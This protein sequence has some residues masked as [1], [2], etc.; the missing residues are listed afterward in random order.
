[1]TLTLYRL[2]LVMTGFVVE[3]FYYTKSILIQTRRV[4]SH[5]KLNKFNYLYLLALSLTSSRINQ[6]VYSSYSVYVFTELLQKT[7]KFYASLVPNNLG[8]VSSN[9]HKS[10]LLN[11][12]KNS[13][14]FQLI[15]RPRYLANF[16]A[17]H[18]HTVKD[19][20]KKFIIF[21]LNMFG[22]AYLPYNIS[23][24]TYNTYVWLSWYLKLNPMNNIF[25][26]KV[27]NY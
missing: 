14:T 5:V 3:N 27:Y 10:V 25:Y 23:F 19:A 9:Y 18:F 16:E 7:W 26:L 11:L 4:R 2:P 1:M 24:N 22:V 6:S 13:P 8:L 17:Y 21:F 12:T 15:P 20:F